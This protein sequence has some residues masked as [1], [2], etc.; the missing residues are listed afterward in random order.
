MWGCGGGA[1]GGGG[2][3]RAW[4]AAGRVARRSGPAPALAPFPV[5]GFSSLWTATFCWG[6]RL[7]LLRGC[8]AC[9][10]VGVGLQRR[11]P[12]STSSS[13]SGLSRPVLPCR[14]WRVVGWV[15]FLSDVIGGVERALWEGWYPALTLANGVC[16]IVYV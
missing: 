6:G 12:L 3:A 2:G 4:P 7:V 16:V 10:A 14:L 13:K 15:G 9:H 8:D 11:P 5:Q 1:G